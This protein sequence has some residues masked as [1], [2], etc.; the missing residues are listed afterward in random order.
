MIE[1]NLP[2]LCAILIVVETCVMIATLLWWVAF[3]SDR[4]WEISTATMMY[5]TYVLCK[6]Q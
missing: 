5:C 6:N 4:A 3:D 1:V 2:T